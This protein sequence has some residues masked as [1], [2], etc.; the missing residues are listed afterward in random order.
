MAKCFIEAPIVL[1]FPI[2]FGSICYWLIGF[3]ATVVKF[4]E[5]QL[6]LILFVAVSGSL[7]TFVGSVSPSLVVSA[8]IAPISIITFYLFGGYF[9]NTKSIPIYYNWFK[10]L[11]FFYYGFR[12]M[13]SIEFT[14][15]Q[16][17]PC[18]PNDPGCI[19]VA[20]GSVALHNLGMSDVN[21]WFCLGILV[22]MV[23]VYRF[24]A[25]IAL[26]ILHK[27]VK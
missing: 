25:L 4:L 17:L 21:L 16:F 6:T 8:V 23:F 15:L 12:A 24:L 20:N 27:E 22:L 19:Y 3:Q 7:F 13:C 11:S 5:F 14:G 10:Y 9:I 18:Q 1:I 26:I 2:I